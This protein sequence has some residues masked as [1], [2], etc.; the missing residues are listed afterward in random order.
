MAEKWLDFTGLN[1]AMGV[2]QDL[3]G[4]WVEWPDEIGTAFEGEANPFYGEKHSPETRERMR[5][6]AQRRATTDFAKKQ[7]CANAK[8][9]WMFV[10]PQGSVVWFKGSLNYFCQQRGL[11]TGAMAAIHGERGIRNTTQ[12][13]GWRKCYV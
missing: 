10:S 9:T 11:N 8:K 3:T 13:K 1:E 5:Q 7:R 12:Y 6:A 2:S 4:V